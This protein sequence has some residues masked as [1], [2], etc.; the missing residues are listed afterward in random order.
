MN[1]VNRAVANLGRMAG[2]AGLELDAHGALSLVFNDETTV[3][4]SRVDDRTIELWTPIGG[5]NASAGG[6]TA[7]RAL[8][9]ANYLGEG[10]GSA[11]L[12]L[13]P[14]TGSVVLCER[15]DVGPA[16]EHEFGDRIVQFLKYAAFWASPEG[17]RQTLAAGSTAEL[18]TDPFMMRA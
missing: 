14:E 3:N 7:L 5:I 12:A 18:G 1:D 13:A 11:R 15:F 9:E 10:T 16:S 6:E 4:L 2:I 17:G 8:L